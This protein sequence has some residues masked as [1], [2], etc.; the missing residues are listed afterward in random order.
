MCF[1]SVLY[2][3]PGTV[4][5]SLWR[6]NNSLWHRTVL[7]DFVNIF[8]ATIYRRHHILHVFLCVYIHSCM[9]YFT[10]GVNHLGNSVFWRCLPGN[11][12]L[13]FWVF[14]LAF[15]LPRSNPWWSPLQ[16]IAVVDRMFPTI[17]PLITVGEVVVV[18]VA[19]VGV[20]G[21]VVKM[22][23]VLLL[24]FILTWIFFLS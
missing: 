12:G 17:A 7:I 2:V 4:R 16:L 5:R 14:F 10:N 23:V 18:G 22:C 6:K 20:D 11:I 9:L 13:V 19:E 8:V 21:W 15:G 3:D 24:H 1:V